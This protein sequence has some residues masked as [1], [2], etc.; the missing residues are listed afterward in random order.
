[1]KDREIKQ[2]ISTINPKIILG[3]DPGKTGAM[4]VFRANSKRTAYGLIDII[5][6][7]ED[8]ILKYFIKSNTT[9]DNAV[10]F[11]ENVHA[12]PGQSVV[13]MFSFGKNLGWW[14][15]VLQT[16]GIYTTLVAPQSWSPYYIGRGVKDKKTTARQVAT[17][18]FSRPI[19]RMVDSSGKSWFRLVKH[20][21]RA[22]AA[23]IA[24]YGMF[25][26]DIC[27]IAPSEP[28]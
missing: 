19:D 18:L 28:F 20:N 16:L 25:K 24:A 8:N 22:D 14:Q 11:V 9:G 13:S 27:K 3:V 10:A 12:A 4:A 21:G 15:G 7:N 6:F 23:L 2:Q 26:Y 1:M 5:D 17:K